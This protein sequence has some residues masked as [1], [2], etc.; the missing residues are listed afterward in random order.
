MSIWFQ[1]VGQSSCTAELE[2]EKRNP[3]NC[4]IEVYFFGLHNYYFQC[5]YS[6]M[7]FEKLNDV[8]GVQYFTMFDEATLFEPCDFTNQKLVTGTTCEPIFVF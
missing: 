2:K 8:W 5:V 6:D 4:T 3:V 7:F 1:G